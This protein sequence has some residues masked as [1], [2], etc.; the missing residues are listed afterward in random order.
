MHRSIA[1]LIM[2]RSLADCPTPIGKARR[3]GTH[4]FPPSKAKRL[5][6]AGERDCPQHGKADSVGNESTF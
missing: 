1:A 5:G 4:R 6:Q 3:S 2:I